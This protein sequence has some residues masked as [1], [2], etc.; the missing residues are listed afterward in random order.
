MFVCSG[1]GKPWLY[2][3]KPNG[4][5]DVTESHLAWKM[6][7]GAPLNP[8]PLLIGPDEESAQWVA[9]VANCA[10]APFVILEKHRRSDIDVQISVPHVERWQDHTPVLVDDIISTARTMVRSACTH[11]QSVS[12]PCSLR[13]P[14][15]GSRLT[16]R[17]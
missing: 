16:T 1:Y 15:R 11:R 3:V 17:K 10:G 5:G 14:R 7:R 2:A 12:R 13:S 9:A 6:D 8:S 4:S